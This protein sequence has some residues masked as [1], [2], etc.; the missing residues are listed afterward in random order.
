MGRRSELVLLGCGALLAAV[1][2]GFN[3]LTMAQPEE[4]IKPRWEGFFH[5]T[6]GQQRSTSPQTRK[7][8]RRESPLKPSV[9]SLPER[10]LPSSFTLLSLSSMSD[11]NST[12]SLIHSDSEELLVCH[13]ASPQAQ[14]PPAQLPPVSQPQP[15]HAPLNPLVN[16]HLESFK[17]HPRQSLTPTHIP[18][19]PSS[20][21]SLHR[22]PSDGAIKKSCLP[23]TLQPLPEKTAL[24][25]TGKIF[26]LSEIQI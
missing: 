19:A 24:E 8:F 26:D 10:A 14:A 23:N 18:S 11:C 7:L 6:G 25:N 15:M 13:P 1:G 16:T 5:R 22:T 4:S 21:R 3:L 9:P 17:R 20:A 2:L 12:R